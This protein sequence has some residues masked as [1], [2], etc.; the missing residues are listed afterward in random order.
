MKKKTTALFAT[1]GVLLAGAVAIDLWSRIGRGHPSTVPPPPPPPAVPINASAQGQLHLGELVTA[2]VA[3]MN[4]F[5]PAGGPSEV[6]MRVDLVAQEVSG[7]ARAPMALAIVIDRSGSMAGEKIERA[8]ASAKEL[9]GRL[10]ENDRISVIS[11]ATDVTVDLPL[12]AASSS[13][14]ARINRVIDQIFDGGGTNISGG[15]DAGLAELERAR[16]LGLN[17]R[18]VLLSDGNA[19]QGIVEPR[20][21]SHLAQDAH[22]RGITVSSLGLGLDF[23]EDVMTMIAESGGG[24]YHYIREA[25]QITAALDEEMRGLSALAARKVLVKLNLAPGVSLAEVYGYGVAASNQRGAVNEAIIPIGDMSSGSKRRIVVRLNLSAPAPGGVPIG[26]AGLEYAQAQDGTPASFGGSLAAVAT[27]DQAALIKGERPEVAA[28][29]AAILAAEARRSAAVEFSSGNRGAAMERI[30][31]NLIETRAKAKKYQSVELFDQV[32][33]LEGAASNVAQ[34]DAN[35]DLG[36]DFVKSE[37]YK[38]HRVF[39]Y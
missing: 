29:V 21:L 7:R 35:S 22:D 6:F 12:T 17:A 24:T 5:V 2:D 20:G 32:K 9:V 10:D 3:L 33:E 13:E 19:N 27:Q 28:T 25:S 36:R 14:R 16:S 1:C 18:I 34:E 23:N 15:L 26:T 39:A 30:N 4:D 11:Y 8:R 37:K 31:R 38:A